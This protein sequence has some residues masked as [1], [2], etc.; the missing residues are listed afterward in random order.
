[1]KSLFT[2]FTQLLTELIAQEAAGYSI[3]LAH[4]HPYMEERLVVSRVANMPS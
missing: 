3:K 1:M 4:A 2:Q